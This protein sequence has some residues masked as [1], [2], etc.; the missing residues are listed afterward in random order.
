MEV[1][2]YNINVTV[3]EAGFFQSSLFVKGKFD[4][5]TYA[6]GKSLWSQAAKGMEAL[7][8]YVPTRA[9]T[10]AAKAA[11]SAAKQLCKAHPPAHFF[12]GTEVYSNRL[13]GF[14]YFFISYP[15]TLFTTCSA[16][17]LCL[18]ASGERQGAMCRQDDKWCVCTAQAPGLLGFFSFAHA[19]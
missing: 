11:A 4:V 12:V 10:T 18:M 15:Q 19:T 6:A 7:V 2:P 1:A 13:L 8:D 9:T 5:D 14:I 17:C 16:E 3:I